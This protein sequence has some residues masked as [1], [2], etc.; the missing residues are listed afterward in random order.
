VG[1]VR[2]EVLMGV[3]NVYSGVPSERVRGKELGHVT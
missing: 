2:E 3:C 1:Y